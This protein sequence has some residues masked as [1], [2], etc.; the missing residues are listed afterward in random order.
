[1]RTAVTA[2]G[3]VT[4]V[5]ALVAPVAT[6]DVPSRMREWSTA[7]GVQCTH[8]HVDVAWSDSSKPTFEF[9]Q[10]MRRM[11]DALN[12]G[13]LKD[14]G[15]IACWTCH[16]GQTRPPRLPA[17]SWRGIR[18]QH[19]GEFTSPAGA[20]TMSVYAASLGVECSH[21]HE[22]GSFTA[23]TRPAHAMVAKMLPI[24]DEIPKHFDNSRMPT[25][26]CYM[27]HQGR[28]KPERSPQ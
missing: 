6:Q 20:L 19:V 12:A 14:V 13:A 4:F 16:R 10:R 21:C 7:L 8:C 2:Y 18:D 1:M 28:P 27:C 25:T 23:P 24:F 9:A 17:A 26:Q 5:L 15:V 3:V 11:V 22:P